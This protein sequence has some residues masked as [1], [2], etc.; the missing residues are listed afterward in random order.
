MEPKTSLCLC[1]ARS[2]VYEITILHCYGSW[3]VSQFE[4]GLSLSLVCCL[5]V[6][7]SL[8]VGVFMFSGIAVSNHIKQNII[9]V[10]YF[11]ITLK[12]FWG[13]KKKYCTPSEIKTV[14]MNGYFHTQ[15]AGLHSMMKQFCILTMQTKNIIINYNINQWSYCM[16]FSLLLNWI[17]HS[18]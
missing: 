10:H 17:L 16:I 9:I 18:P 11:W 2:H 5:I 8:L 13:A 7:F 4:V 1:R 3:I 6:R 15:Q 14:L 12:H